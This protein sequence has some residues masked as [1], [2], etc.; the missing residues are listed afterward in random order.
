[1]YH[2][3]WWTIDITLNSLHAP[4]GA[5][6][7]PGLKPAVISVFISFLTFV[8]SYDRDLLSFDLETASRVTF[9]E[10]NLRTKI[11]PSLFSVVEL[12]AEKNGRV[13]W[14][15]KIRKR[16]SRTKSKKCRTGKR[17]T[18]KYR[19]EKRMI[20][21]CRVEI[22]DDTKT[23]HK[24][25]VRKEGHKIH[26]SRNAQRNNHCSWTRG[27][28]PCIRRREK[29]VLKITGGQTLQELTLTQDEKTGLDIS[30]VDN[31]GVYCTTARMDIAGVDKQEGQ[32]PLTGQR[33]PPI[34]GG[35]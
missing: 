34:S 31:H 13:N 27:V 24:R 33:A 2:L 10:K 23:W 29:S 28:R 30:G 8:R 21:V 25:V 18:G 19:T 9:A 20:R 14:K 15:C 35:P 7:P 1:M 17:R 26:R 5:I 6:F 4:S 3:K 16:R 12:Q 22:N 32:H 11:E